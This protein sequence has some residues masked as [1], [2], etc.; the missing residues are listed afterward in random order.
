M[1]S[2]AKLWFD[3]A[4]EHFDDM[5]Y[6]YKG[7]RYSMSVYCAHQALEKI[8]KAVIVENIHMTP[9]KIH[10]LDA[11][12]R[13]TKLDFPDPWYEDLAEITRHYWRIRYPDF[14]QFVYVTL[15]KV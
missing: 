7:R 2:E 1:K 14:Q 4:K 8:L 9:P 3:Q 13:Q 12:A 15:E 6:L 5:V 10:N 11:L